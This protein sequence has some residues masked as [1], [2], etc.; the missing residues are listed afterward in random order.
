MGHGKWV[1]KFVLKP[2]ALASPGNLLDMQTF[3][4]GHSLTEAETLGLGW[5]RWTLKFEKHCYVSCMSGTKDLKGKE[6]DRLPDL[7]ELR[8]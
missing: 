1:S 6:K 7:R 4:P 2:A 3:R 8:A 5:F